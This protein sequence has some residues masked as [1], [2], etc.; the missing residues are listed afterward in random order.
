MRLGQDQGQGQ[1]GQGGVL[2]QW[3]TESCEHRIS[4]PVGPR[5]AGVESTSNKHQ[6]LPTLAPE[7]LGSVEATAEGDLG[8]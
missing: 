2:S 1:E 8:E 4:C 6:L 5:W 3:S 7:G